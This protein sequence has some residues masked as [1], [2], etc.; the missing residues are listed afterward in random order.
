[1]HSAKI[2]TLVSGDCGIFDAFL[3]NLFFCSD[4]E[5]NLFTY[6][7]SNGS[8]CLNRKNVCFDV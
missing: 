4:C 8:I 6:F 3:E 7:Y 2:V 1:M 5:F